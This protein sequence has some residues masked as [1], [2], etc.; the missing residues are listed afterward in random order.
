ME[1]KFER[2]IWYEQQVVDKN[3]ETKNTEDKI[4]INL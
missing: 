4:I 2:S 1:T 3:E